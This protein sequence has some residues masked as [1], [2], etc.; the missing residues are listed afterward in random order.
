MS[1]IKAFKLRDDNEDKMTKVKHSAWHLQLRDMNIANTIRNNRK[2]NNNSILFTKHH[3][4]GIAQK[5]MAALVVLI[6]SQ[7][8]K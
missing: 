1:T 8:F 6:I 7:T 5:L 4:N 2:K 3:D